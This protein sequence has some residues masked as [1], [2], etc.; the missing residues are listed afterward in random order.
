MKEEALKVIITNNIMRDKVMPG[1]G[2]VGIAILE[3]QSLK[4][5]P[6]ANDSLGG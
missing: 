3:E 6:A 5:E 4:E 1:S 2:A